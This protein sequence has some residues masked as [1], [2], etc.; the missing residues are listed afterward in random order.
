MPPD[1][2]L[3]NWRSTI[4]GWVAVHES[5]RDLSRWPGSET[6]DIVYEDDSSILTQLLIEKG[7]LRGSIWRGCSPTYYI[8]V[9]TT[10]GSLNTQFYCSQHQYDLMEEMKLNEAGVANRIYLIA[11]VYALGTSGMGLKLYLDPANLR[12]ERQLQFKADK[13]LVTPLA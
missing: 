11:R 10:P 2:G 13:Y 12:R 6:S 7:Y 3:G 5:Y 8:E 9:K 4:R 1:F